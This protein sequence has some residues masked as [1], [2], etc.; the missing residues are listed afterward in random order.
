MFRVLALIGIFNIFA[1]GEVYAM[2]STSKKRLRDTEQQ[3][4]LRTPVTK[5]LKVE[6]KEKVAVF[7][8]LKNKSPLTAESEYFLLAK[9][10]L[11]KKLYSGC[12]AACL[13]HEDPG[14]H[15][16]KYKKRNPVSSPEAREIISQLPNNFWSRKLHFKGKFVYQNDSLFD[17]YA[18]IGG[19]TNLERMKEGRAPLIQRGDKIY[20]VELHHLTQKDTG[21]KADPIVEM[22]SRYHKGA[23]KD[24]MTLEVDPKTKAIVVVKH[25]Q[26]KAEAYAD[27]TSEQFVIADGIH[28]RCS[29]SLINRE[30]DFDPFR[31]VYWIHRAEVIEKEGIQNEK[32]L[33]SFVTPLKFFSESSSE[34]YLDEEDKENCPNPFNDLLENIAPPKF[35]TSFSPPESPVKLQKSKVESPLKVKNLNTITKEL[36][37]N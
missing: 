19:R 15:I 18:I 13:K 24:R 16:K 21:T 1:F 27:C 23:E 37:P 25:S 22:S 12:A 8:S 9:E 29:K 32:N 6:E 5:K 26:T 33:P 7:P 14:K 35:L 11:V 2:D 28:F 4:S 30:K 20:G 31:K 10:A 36:F 3:D 17:P 34:E